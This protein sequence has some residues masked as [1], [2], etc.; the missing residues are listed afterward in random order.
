MAATHYRIFAQTRPG[1]HTVTA[2]ALDRFI[3]C[4]WPAHIPPAPGTAMLLLRENVARGTRGYVLAEGENGLNTLETI[5]KEE[6]VKLI[7]MLGLDRNLTG[8]M[9]TTEAER[10]LGHSATLPA[11]GTVRARH[12]FMEK[13][14]SDLMADEREQYERMSILELQSRYGANQQPL[15]DGVNKGHTQNTRATQ[16][17]LPIPVRIDP[18]MKP[19]SMALVNKQRLDAD[20]PHFYTLYSGYFNSGE[21]RIMGRITNLSVSVDDL[22]DDLESTEVIPRQIVPESQRLTPTP[23]RQVGRNYWARQASRETPRPEPPPP[24]VVEVKE[25]REHKRQFNFD[26]EV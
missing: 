7:S 11:P 19:G 25:R 18:D 4:L 1:S 16:R 10:A 6:T 24:P 14:I 2:E 17:S 12:L 15:W 22:P 26:G 13:P 20:I 8:A 21:P 9:L 23:E 3:A 5:C